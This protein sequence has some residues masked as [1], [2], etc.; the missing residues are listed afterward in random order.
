MSQQQVREYSS[1]VR[2]SILSV[3]PVDLLSMW[4]DSLLFDSED[5]RESE[6]K[7]HYNTNA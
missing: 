5:V 4:L 7:D 1:T 2:S 3:K 6:E